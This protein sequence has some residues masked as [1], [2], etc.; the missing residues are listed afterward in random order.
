MNIACNVNFIMN[1]TARNSN[2]MMKSNI[3]EKKIIIKTYTKSQQVFKARQEV[4]GVAL[5]SLRKIARRF[6]DFHEM[7]L[8][9]TV[10]R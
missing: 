1:D 5:L 6:I 3:E 8:C 9:T 2:N 7:L 4:L 10:I